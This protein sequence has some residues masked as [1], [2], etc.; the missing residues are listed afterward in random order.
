MLLEKCEFF[1]DS[2]FRQGNEIHSTVQILS[3]KISPLSIGPFPTT[4]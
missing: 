4:F 2:S 1:S 3:R